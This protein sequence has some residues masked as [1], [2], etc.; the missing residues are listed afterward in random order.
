MRVVEGWACADAHEF[1]RANLDDGNPRI[2]LE[3]RNDMVGHC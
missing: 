2:I 1:R 3:M